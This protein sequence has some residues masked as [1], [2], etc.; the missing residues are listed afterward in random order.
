[1]VLILI[2]TTGSGMIDTMRAQKKPFQTA[3]RRAIKSSELSLVQI[4]AETGVTRGSIS[5]FLRGERSMRLDLADTLAEFFGLRVEE[6][7]GR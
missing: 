6:G 3:L 5:R 2:G 1:M 7:A 4:E